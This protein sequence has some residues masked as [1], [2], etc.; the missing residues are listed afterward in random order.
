[1]KTY[2]IIND[3]AEYAGYL[4]DEQFLR[5][6]GKRH[7]RLTIYDSVYGIP[8]SEKIVRYRLPD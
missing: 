2:F 5:L 3:M 8:I 6:N 4:Y 7:C 1:M